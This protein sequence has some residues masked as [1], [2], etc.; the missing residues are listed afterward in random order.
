MFVFA[1]AMNRGKLTGNFEV[2]LKEKEREVVE[3]EEDEKN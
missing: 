3:D 1:G 2:D